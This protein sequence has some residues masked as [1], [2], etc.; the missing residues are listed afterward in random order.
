MGKHSQEELVELQESPNVL[1]SFI[2]SRIPTTYN[3]INSQ[4]Y[5]K[6]MSKDL[7]VK[8]KSAFSFYNT[9]QRKTVTR[10]DVLAGYEVAGNKKET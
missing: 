8:N 2:Y 10:R 4:S 6:K 1:S 5:N 3:I 9:W 7:K